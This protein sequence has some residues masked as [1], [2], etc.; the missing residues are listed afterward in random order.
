MDNGRTVRPAVLFML[1]CVSLSLLPTLCISLSLYTYIYTPLSPFI[2]PFLSSETSIGL[3]C[4]WNH[5]PI[6]THQFSVLP[7]MSRSFPQCSFV[8]VSFLL[9][10]GYCVSPLYIQPGDISTL[11]EPSSQTEYNTELPLHECLHSSVRTCM[12]LHMFT[13]KNS[14]YRPV[15]VWHVIMIFR[16]DLC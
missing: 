8:S 5:K 6:N 4:R 1:N 14:L 12:S 10:C 11:Y 15:N 13:L 16:V 3:D 7:S 2:S 9:H